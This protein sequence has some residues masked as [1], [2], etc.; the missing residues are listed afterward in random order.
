MLDYWG[1][2]LRRNR[3]SMVKPI[4]WILLRSRHIVFPARLDSSFD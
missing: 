4:Y 1:A 3:R 2:L